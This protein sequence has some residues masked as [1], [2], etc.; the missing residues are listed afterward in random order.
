M[1][2]IGCAN[3]ASDGPPT[4]ASTGLMDAPPS[5]DGPLGSDG[6]PGVADA[7]PGPGPVSC[8]SNTCRNDQTCE[9]GECRFSCVGTSVPG[10]YATLQS[11]VNALVGVDND[12]T[13]CL[14]A[15]DY[16]ETVQLTASRASNKT[17]TIIGRGMDATT[18]QGSLEFHNG[19][20]Q[21]TL[22]GFNISSPA[23]RNGSSALGLY[24]YTQSTTPSANLVAM[25]LSGDLG[26]YV[27]GKF[28]VSLDGCDV[29]AGHDAIYIINTTGNTIPINA[30][31]TNSYI[32]NAEVALSSSPGPTGTAMLSVINT[33]VA[34]VQYGIAL[35][36]RT[37]TTL[38][39]N[40]LT[41]ASTEMLRW[42]GSSTVTS[43]HN[44]LWNNVTNYAGAAVEGANTIKTDCLLDRLARIPTLKPGSPCRNAGS[45]AEAP[46]HDFWFSAR[47]PSVTPPDIGP[48]E[49]P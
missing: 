5:S 28:N 18:L 39:N 9:Q 10:D 48:I 36:S 8:G 46:L 40:L 2:S 49:V 15:S 19:W 21:I 13:I 43:H 16:N 12:V 11:A 31:I 25:K 24:G 47:M 29:Q 44:A 27:S 1:T 26:M 38:V 20:R 32:H 45:A 17:L 14:T 37:Q 7:G 23:N 42:D 30:H 6:P 22:R 34:D 35:T 3:G 41:G 4:D 33:L